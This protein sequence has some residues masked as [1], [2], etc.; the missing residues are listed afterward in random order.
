MSGKIYFWEVAIRQHVC[1]REWS[2]FYLRAIADKIWIIKNTCACPSSTKNVFLD[3]FTLYLPFL[4][5]CCIVN[6]LITVGLLMYYSS[7]L[8]TQTDNWPTQT[9]FYRPK[10]DRVSPIS[11]RYWKV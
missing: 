6:Y 10:V 7:T 1:F 3:H 4:W 9:F 5:Q 11:K 8:K 2:N